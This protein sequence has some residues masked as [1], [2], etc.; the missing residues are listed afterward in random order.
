MLG[1]FINN[2]LGGNV[3]KS[4]LILL[5]SVFFIFIGYNSNFSLA[6]DDIQALERKLEYLKS[7][8]RCVQYL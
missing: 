7:K 8:E 2:F 6:E 5:Y 3:M 4:I 1:L